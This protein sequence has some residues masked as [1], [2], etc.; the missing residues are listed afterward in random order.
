MI[1]IDYVVRYNDKRCSTG[2][3]QVAATRV[4]E[5]LGR[6]RDS[7]RRVAV[8]ADPTADVTAVPLLVQ[9][10]R[11]WVI[12]ETSLDPLTIEDAVQQCARRH[13]LVAT[14]LDDDPAD[15]LAP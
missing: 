12:V 8:A 15:S 3:R 2:G 7:L 14:L 6:F 5:L 9:P 1:R 10:I 11:N 4:L 13:D